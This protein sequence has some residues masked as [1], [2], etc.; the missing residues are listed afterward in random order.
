MTSFY[1][2]TRILFTFLGLFGLQS[3]AQVLK[4]SA[5][6]DDFIKDLPIMMATA[7]NSLVAASG[8][9][10][11]QLWSK[12]FTEAQK[13]KLTSVCQKMLLLKAHKP[14]PHFYFFFEMLNAAVE[15]GK[16]TPTEI[17]SLLSVTDEVLD[18]Y[19]L[20]ATIKW[21]EGM[22]FFYTKKLVYTSNFNKLYA[23]GGKFTIKF[24]GEYDVNANKKV[25]DSLNVKKSA[26][27]DFDSN[28]DISKPLNNIKYQ[29]K[30][31][32]KFTGAII[33]FE[34]TNLIMV[35]ASD[36]V[37]LTNTNG[38]VSMK[39]GIFSGY[40][41]DFT[42]ESAGLKGIK[43]S[44]SE[45]F[46][47]IKNP[48]FSAEEATLVYPER[49]SQPIK[50][51]FEYKS[52][53]RN[54]GVAATYPRFMS[55]QGNANVKGINQNIEYRGGFSLSGRRI[56]SSSV[57]D[58]FAS[59]VV[60]N[61]NAVAFKSTSLQFEMS[62]SLISATQA[63]YVMYI[64]KD[65]I[66]HPSV[67][68]LYDQKRGIVKLNKNNAGGFKDT[69]FFDSYHH[70]DISTDAALWDMK[71]ERMDF[72]IIS[73]KNF[74]PATFES[75][76][77]YSSERITDFNSQSGFNPLL[78][79]G[80]YVRAKNVTSFSVKELS[81]ATNI[82]EP[83]MRGGLQSLLQRG[84]IDFN[85]IDDIYRT[86]RKT[87]HTI[88]AFSGKKDYDNFLISSLFSSKDSTTNATINMKDKM[89]TIR[90]VRRFSLSDSLRVYV[91]PKDD[92]VQVGYNRDFKVTGQ[93]KV[94]N[95][96]FTGQNMAFNYDRF[97]I[98]LTKIDSITFIPQ[99]VYR[100]GGKKEIG[101]HIRFKES[102][103]LFLNLPDNKSGRVRKPEFPR[104]VI[105]EEVFVFFDQNERK[106]KYKRDVFFK[107]PNIDYD[108]LNVKD[109]EFVGSFNS[110]GIFQPFTET[111]VVMPDTSLGFLHKVP[112]GTYQLFGG[113][114]S[115]KFDGNLS[116][117][118]KG[119][120]SKGEINHLAARLVADEIAFMSDSIKAKGLL[121][122]VKETISP[123]AYFPK[124]D[125]KDYAM[126]WVPKADSMLIS[127]K[128]SFAFYQ[129]T[130]SLKGDIVVR[131]KGL[132]GKGKIT[133]SDSETESLGFQFNKEGFTADSAQFD[134]KS[135][136]AGTKPILQGRNVDVNFN[137][138]NGLVN[139][140][141]M[142]DGVASNLEFPYAAYKTNINRA[143]WS[144]KD[145]KISMKGDV[146][147]SLFTAINPIHENLSFNGNEAVYDIAK[148][149]LNIGGVPAIK[150]ADASVSPYQGAVAIRRDG[151]M[152]PFTKAKIKIDT[153]NGFHNLINGNIQILSKSK[154]VGDA[155]YQF[156]N[157]SKDT[158]NIKMGNF[159]LK[160]LVNTNSRKK[161]K[162]Y[163]TV[164]KASIDERDKVYISPKVLYRGEMTM[165]ASEKNLLLDGFVRPE[166]KKY[167]GLGGYWIA[168]KGNKS[169][170][171]T[172]QVDKNLKAEGNQ[173]LLAGLHYRTASTGLYPT[174]M[175]SKE[176]ETDQ[177]IFSVT[178]TF[179]RDE[180][181]KQFTIEEGAKPD[182]GLW[183]K[184][185]FAFVDNQGLVKFDGKFMFFG[186]E[187]LNKITQ[188]SGTGI[189]ELDSNRVTFNTMVVM[190]FPIVS[191]ILKNMAEKIVKTKLEASLPS[192]IMADNPELLRKMA[193]LI[194][195][196]EAESYRPRAAKE[197]VAL[198][199]FTSNFNAALVFS[200]LK[201]R[202]SEKYNS[203]YSIGDIGLSNLGMNDINAK[204]PGYIE[205]RKTPNGDEIY[206]YL[207]ASPEVWYFLGYRDGQLGIVAN[208]TTFNDLLLSK[209]NS[210]KDKKKNAIEIISVGNEEK[211][212]FVTTFKDVYLNTKKQ[213]KK[214][215]GSTISTAPKPVETPKTA[216]PKPVEAPKQEVPKK[217]GNE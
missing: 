74:V 13:I 123:Q 127:T 47:A 180:P 216:T 133:R 202:W 160:E 84:Y 62:D 171:V 105:P 128:G 22:L 32:P 17:D 173:V 178:G 148:E 21:Y 79:V 113:A 141:T 120:R 186:D 158:F 92:I 161:E 159:E 205:F 117:D 121:G 69:P 10:I 118:M 111:I 56:Y 182:N 49:L 151:D 8:D 209:L 204:I 110:G 116:M 206:V 185:R 61:G 157:I 87:Q 211:I 78:M 97:D 63:S 132:F 51:I 183:E 48:K 70:L 98:K 94:G 131:S 184:N 34:N 197:H 124:V 71:K 60:K 217:D 106:A 80:N 119:L 83:L 20:S 82:P 142:K 201:M 89:L 146:K 187:K 44:F 169:E 57:N 42:W 1:K 7:N 149:T 167:P 104:L 11:V 203:F 81:K 143:D 214:G 210:K 179:S 88:V 93:I 195:G 38:A 177:D 65:S 192:A 134:V 144:I 199:N 29:K 155:T 103:T 114:S 191:D 64:D 37:T 46:F 43:A 125:V 213:P 15:S 163:Y 27:D 101:G 139:I 91:L 39:E 6:A 198:N 212:M 36:S 19:D 109:M 107:I 154:F 193:H 188:S 162:A 189:F 77:F 102:G 156:V 35:T 28:Q 196:K 145:K 4:L 164:A 50:G 136:L 12:T 45:Y 53:K 9:K 172:L 85:P 3:H 208:E 58:R 16:A 194:G 130:T 76:D 72:Y 168:Y 99:K 30:V 18:H 67:K 26:F 170:N 41:G 90:G 176:S 96:R 165:L 31:P 52:E 215:Q 54:A 86:N 14:S 147:S 68:L 2:K 152:M 66:T 40:G 200:D 181:Q 115:V 55:F 138:I 129:N 108:S 112:T 33:E 175:S 174:F 23:S 25:M 207:E 190:N 24:V 5:K 166:L 95:F 73:G 59:I 140:S 137:V 135:I 75:L 153:L 126:K 150:T 122:E 100:R